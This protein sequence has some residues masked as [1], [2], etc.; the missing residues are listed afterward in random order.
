MTEAEW[1]ACSDPMPMLEFLR[2]KVSERELRLFTC[3]TARLL[4]D[5]FP[6]GLLKEAVEAGERHADGVPCENECRRYVYELHKL[7]V[8]YGKET[9]R[10][11]FV[12]QPPVAVSALFGAIHAVGHWAA[13]STIPD[14]LGWREHS[15]ATGHRQPELLRDIFGNPF[16]PAAVTQGMTSPDVVALAGRIYR[17]RA[18]AELGELAG[19]L[20]AVGCDD[21][22]VLD[23]CRSSGRHVRGCWVLDLILAKE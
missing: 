20:Q 2:G 11:W 8:D 13:I 6:A 3:A 23:H 15:K 4:W 5:Q 19:L 1:L 12:D 17:D 9:G 21:V 10:N 22:A 16:R 18:F 7:P 14:R